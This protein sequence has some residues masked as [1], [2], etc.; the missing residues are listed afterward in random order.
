MYKFITWT[1]SS[2]DN[3]VEEIG[4]WCTADRPTKYYNHSGKQMGSLKCQTYFQ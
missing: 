1:M 4:F 2:V 3:N